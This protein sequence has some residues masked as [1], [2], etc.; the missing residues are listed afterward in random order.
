MT[1]AKASPAQKRK[2][3]PGK[4]KAKPKE[5]AAPKTA[6]KKAPAPTVFAKSMAETTAPQQPKPRGPGKPFQPGQ[7]GNP[8]GRPKGARHKL[9]QD[10]IRVLAED[11]AANGK[12]VIEKLRDE[13]PAAY[14][15]TI[16]GV[17]PKIIEL[18]DE[19]DD[20]GG[21]PITGAIL[22]TR[23]FIRGLCEEHGG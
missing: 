5:K 3:A 12:E 11:F 7:S 16:S 9:A 8:T 4:G 22:I 14:A 19:S 1:K 23:D 13:N 15:K 6:A 17:L 2:P 20:S 18:E 21:K 10:F